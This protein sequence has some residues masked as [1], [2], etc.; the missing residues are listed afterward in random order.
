MNL[1]TFRAKSMAQAL[2]EV[3][4]QLGKDAVILHTRA[5]RVGAVMGMGGHDEYEITAADATAAAAANARGPSV[6]QTQA[7]GKPASPAQRR[8]QL[9][10]PIEIPAPVGD[11]LHHDTADFV[12]ATFSSIGASSNTILTNN[13]NGAHDEGNGSNGHQAPAAPTSPR[14]QEIKPIPAATPDLLGALATRAEFAPEDPE[15]F[16]QLKDELGSIRRLVG[17]LLTETRRATAGSAAWGSLSGI[18]P[19]SMAGLGEP[20]MDMSLALQESGLRAELTDRV[21]GATR[22]ELTPDELKDTTIVTAAVQR[23]LASLIPVTGHVT[24][25]GQR[26]HQ[27]TGTNRPL[28][29]ALIGPTGVGK[30]TT[31]AKLAASYTLKHNAKVGFITCDTYRIAAVDQLRTYASILNIPLK[32]ALT[33]Q[34]AKQAIT[35]I[36]DCSVILVDSAGRAPQDTPRLDELAEFLTELAPDETHLVLSVGQAEDVL[37]Q[38]AAKFSLLRPTHLLLS[39]LDEAVRFGVIANVAQSVCGQSNLKVSYVTTGQEV[40]AQIELAH[41]DRL[42]RLVMNAAQ[43][44]SSTNTS[45]QRG[46]AETRQ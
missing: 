6:K 23:H 20:L 46:E 29:I 33:P 22:D 39:K 32:V 21:I 40:P 30:T 25:P 15:A 34:E 28:I 27:A 14:I 3:K 5:Y 18:M 1:K 2:A 12:P 37:C 26:V 36:S 45:S 17:Q 7:D 42:A 35:E 10:T 41:P 8:K 9:T 11:S 4:K 44:N 24:R 38:A 19:T 16:S 43:N 13:G 31:I